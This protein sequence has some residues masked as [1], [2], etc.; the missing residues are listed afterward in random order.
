MHPQILKNAEC[1]ALQQNVGA[2]VPTRYTL[3]KSFPD[4]NSVITVIANLMSF[5]NM[6]DFKAIG[7][8]RKVHEN[9]QDN[10]L[11]I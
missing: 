1:F 10:L 3:G 7:A 5:L 8:F 9:I 6:K 4:P 2:H 11:I